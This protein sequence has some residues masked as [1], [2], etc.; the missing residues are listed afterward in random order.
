MKRF[1]IFFVGLLMASALGITACCKNDDD[2]KGFHFD[3]K[4]FI[5]KWDVWK[6]QKIENY[7][8]IMEW[9]LPT[10]PN[11]TR[12]LPLYKYKTK[13]IVKNGVMDSFEYTGGVPYDFYGKVI[14]PQYTSISDMYQKIYDRAQLE[15]EWWKENG[16][17]GVIIF[18]RYD[19]KYDEKLH[20][21]TF[22]EPVSRWAPG[23]IVDTMDHAV[24][25]SE[26]TIL[27]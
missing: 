12:Y 2:I 4:T 3:E 25:I 9:E 18:T 19:L 14:E 21:I 26:F 22:F 20:F 13:I 10:P 6:E 24:I 5:A 7:S 16:D 8:F 15:R 27:D 17:R 11:Q 1:F 23:W